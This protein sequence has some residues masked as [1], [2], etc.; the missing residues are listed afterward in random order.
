MVSN[1]GQIVELL[2]VAFKKMFPDIAHRIEEPEVQEW[3]AGSL[4]GIVEYSGTL[5]QETRKQRDRRME[6]HK[7]Y[8]GDYKI[9]ASNL[10][11]TYPNERELSPQDLIL[12]VYNGISSVYDVLGVSQVS[13]PTTNGDF[14]EGTSNALDSNKSSE[15]E[16][17]TPITQKSVPEVGTE[18]KESGVQ[19]DSN[20]HVEPKHE[21]VHN[22]EAVESVQ[23]DTEQST[24]SNGATTVADR[25][26]V[27]SEQI[28]KTVDSAK[29]NGMVAGKQDTAITSSE[30]V[31][32]VTDTE[33]QTKSNNKAMEESKMSN[34]AELEKMAEA[35]ANQMGGADTLLDQGAPVSNVTAS[36]EEMKETTMKVVSALEASIPERKAWVKENS[37]DAIIVVKEPAAK[38]ALGTMG[39]LS[40]KKTG[41]NA[42]TPEAAIAEKIQKFVTAVYGSPISEEDWK[43]LPEESRYQQVIKVDK[44]AAPAK[45]GAAPKATNLAKAKKVYEV[46]SAIKNNPT[47]EFAAFIDDKKISFNW[48][49]VV[50][51]GVPMNRNTLIRTLLDKSVSGSVVGDGTDV[52]NVG[53]GTVF[54]LGKA[55]NKV[56]NKQENIAGN[57]PKA[58][59]KFVITVKNK[60]A[61]T[62]QDNHV[63][64]LLTQPAENSDSGASFPVAIKPEGFDAC[65]GA[66]SYVRKT[67]AGEDAIR[68][69]KDKNGNAKFKTGVYT[70]RVTVPVSDVKKE[71][72][73][74][75]KSV[76]GHDHPTYVANY[77]GITMP[78]E[79]DSVNSDAGLTKILAQFMLGDIEMV[80]GSETLKNLARVQKAAQAEADAEEAAQL[81]Q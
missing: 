58:D 4:I 59:K 42:T 44:Q 2:S 67:E 57:A 24:S 18:S 10:R 33:V 30:R 60:A 64:Y 72:G 17:E 81:D 12:K 9:L 65:A 69:T 1:D 35:A 53:D 77:W 45:E 52:E 54:K 73:E 6:C 20:G 79:K 14:E 22:V 25:K 32:D 15:R 48:K 80:E 66:F 56:N 61:F 19:N 37:V 29:L 27:E 16:V 47:G 31:G 40:Y 70:M 41:N 21:E 28:E 68:D 50:L 75:F 55:N 38:R 11:N 13:N 3:L 8:D 74:Q 78:Q 46:L 49:G 39:K 63:V 43:A 7:V 76:E 36:K 5:P 34:F 62:A 71:I 26:D 23:K 51:A